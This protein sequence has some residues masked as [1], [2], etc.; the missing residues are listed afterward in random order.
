[1]NSEVIKSF[2]VSLGFEV[3]SGTLAKFNQG[4]ASASKRILGLYASIKVLSAGI[5]WS[6]SK[7]SEGF[8]QMGYEYRII[9]PAIN[10]TLQLRRELLKAY[11]AAGVN[12]VQAIQGSIKF[13]M[14]LAKTQMVFKAI[15]GSIALKFFPLLTKQMDIF[16]GKIYANMPKIL[17]S[18]QKFVNFIFKAFE[19]TTILGNRV[20]GILQR[21][22]DFFA[23]LHKAT[24]GWSTIIMGAVAAW[25]ILNLSFL[26][27][28]LGMIIAGLL[29]LLTLWDDFKTFQEGGQS[30]INWGSDATKTI[31]GIISVVTA[32]AIG[33]KAVTISIAAFNAIMGVLLPILSAVRMAIA[34]L[35][36]VAAL[37]PFGLLVMGVTALIAAIVLLIKYWD[38]IKAGIGSFF[39]GIGEKVMGFVGGVGE[40]GLGL[41]TA[42]LG[43]QQ[44]ASNNTNQ[45]VAQQTNI[46]VMGSA[47]SNATAKAVASQQ[48]RVN[49]DMVRNMRGAAR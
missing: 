26:A 2:L 39:S 44:A 3:D 5:F 35:S 46:N 43:A 17:A 11:S 23:K 36:L 14:A 19:A 8:E 12:I 34:T 49:F 24:D 9:A 7:I 41:G 6:I 27:T 4:I 13:N 22:Y 16:R 1:M 30:L 33:I 18:L 31:V 38:Q 48:S 29:T 47:D 32:L 21:V 25:R 28:P 15:A 42:P 10:K 45:N 40:G 37:N 20:W